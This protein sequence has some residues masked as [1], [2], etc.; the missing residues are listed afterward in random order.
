LKS[1]YFS[2]RRGYITFE[3]KHKLFLLFRLSGLVDLS[4][5]LAGVSWTFRP[6][7]RWSFCPMHLLSV[8]LRNRRQVVK[9][10]RQSTEEV[11]SSE[12]N[13]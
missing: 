2:F 11:Y 5:H 9:L 3:T 1:F 4:I 7:L 6:I 10:S 8:I 12:I 13:S